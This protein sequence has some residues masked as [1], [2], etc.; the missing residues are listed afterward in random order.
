MT[1]PRLSGVGLALALPGDIPLAERLM[2]TFWVG[3]GY[4]GDSTCR[5]S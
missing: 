5:T 4:H 3:M 1:N 2:L